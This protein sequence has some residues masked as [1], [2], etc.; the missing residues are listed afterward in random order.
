MKHRLSAASFLLAASLLVSPPSFADGVSGTIRFIGMIVEPPCSFAVDA[1]N[2]ARASVRPE[3]PRPASGQIAFV[4]AAT[5]QTVRTTTFTQLSHSIDLPNR[6]N[7][8]HS[9]MIAIVTYQ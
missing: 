7:N 5:Q 8:A 6:A 3:C 4:D 1:A 2:A 9:P